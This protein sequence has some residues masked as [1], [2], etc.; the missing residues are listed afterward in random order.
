MLSARGGIWLEVGHW[1]CP[2]FLLHHGH[3]LNTDLCHYLLHG[4]SALQIGD[5]GLN[6]WIKI[7]PSPP[8]NFEYQVFCPSL[9]KLSKNR[10]LAFNLSSLCYLNLSL[11]KF[12]AQN[13]PSMIL[14]F[15]N[16]CICI[17]ECRTFTCYTFSSVLFF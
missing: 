15:L 6:L 17:I 5:S 2:S 4:I 7:N 1:V 9:R 10:S 14:I 11:I 12:G 8:L 3:W 13:K 16:M